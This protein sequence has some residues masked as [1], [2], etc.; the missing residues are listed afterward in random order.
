[1]PWPGQPCP[2]PGVGCLYVWLHAVRSQHGLLL[3]CFSL[4]LM[5]ILNK[6]QAPW[7]LWSSPV[8]PRQDRAAAGPEG[9]A[10][11][12]CNNAIWP[13]QWSNFSELETTKLQVQ[14]HPPCK[15]NLH[16]PQPSNIPLLCPR[17]RP[18]WLIPSWFC[19]SCSSDPFQ[20]PP[21]SSCSA[22][23]AA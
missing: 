23:C 17:Q 6:A 12:L 22:A 19:V 18:P 7:A 16:F 9:M 21:D 20:C 14:H 1:M 10:S 15:L 13:P 11:L 3:H 2:Q 4:K 5:L 8:Q